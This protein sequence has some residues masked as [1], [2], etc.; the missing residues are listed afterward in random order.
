MENRIIVIRDKTSDVRNIPVPC[1][2]KQ[3]RISEMYLCDKFG[4]EKSRISEVTQ[5]GSGNGSMVIE[6]LEEVKY[7]VVSGSKY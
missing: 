3:R 7:D 4:L 1:N 6:I 5:I 2:V